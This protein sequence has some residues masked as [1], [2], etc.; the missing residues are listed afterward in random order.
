MQRLELTLHPEKTK[1]VPMWRGQG[2]FDFLGMHHK[3]FVMV[4]KHARI[5]QATY[6][7]PSMKAMKK[8]R[9]AVKDELS[10]R[11]VLK[12]DIKELVNQLNPKICGWRNYYGMNTAK[13]WLRKVDWYIFERF[14][15]W[16]NKKTQQKG[17]Y[18]RMGKVYQILQNEGL[19]KLVN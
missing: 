16:Y 12:M 14:T 8:M 15:I 19:L 1:L 4:A 11:S 2:G 5:Y 3:N 10:H 7:Y 6:Q 17:H 9:A 18:Q 13:Q